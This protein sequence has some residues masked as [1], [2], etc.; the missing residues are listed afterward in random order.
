MTTAT[1]ANGDKPV[2]AQ[3]RLAAGFSRI[4]LDGTENGKYLAA[5]VAGPEDAEAVLFNTSILTDSRVWTDQA[6]RAL[7]L[8]YRVVC[9][10]F[11]GH[12][13]SSPFSPPYTMQGLIADNISIF[14]ELNIDRAHLVGVSMGGMVG[15]GFGILHPDRIQSLTLCATRGDAPAAFAAGWDERIAL[16]TKLGTGALVQSTCERWLGANYVSHPAYGL[17]AQMIQ[18]TSIE[19]FVG[20]AQAIQKLDLLGDSGKVIAPTLLIVG[21][22]DAGMLQPMH[23]LHEAIKGARLETIANA[24]HL[25]QFDDTNKFNKLLF[26]H[27]YANKA[28]C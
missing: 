6:A 20:G 8:G 17:I 5:Y 15:L 27:M 28:E 18:D 11:R 13:A 19:G 25:P 1:T 10:D 21:Q 23:V 14:D 3:D 2:V 7:A 9:V 22:N 12:G 16:A 4:R 24:G 26:D